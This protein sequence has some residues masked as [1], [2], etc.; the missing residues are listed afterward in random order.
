MKEVITELTKKIDA[1]KNRLIFDRIVEKVTLEETFNLEIEL[2][3]MFPRL[4][5]IVK[6]TDQSEY[7]YWNDGSNGGLLLITFY[8]QIDWNG[9]LALNLNME[10]NYI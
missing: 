4:K 8:P 7:W 10:I 5:K 1:I 9:N 3:K 6:I 2:N